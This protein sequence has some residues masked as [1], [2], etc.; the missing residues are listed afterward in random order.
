MSMRK[1]IGTWVGDRLRKAAGI[2]DERSQLYG[3]NYKFFG[4]VMI[5]LFPRGLTLKTP[6]DFARFA[7]Y[8]LA[9]VKDTRY[10]QQFHE[11]GHADSLD[12][13]VVYRT[14]LNELDHEIAA[15]LEEES[16]K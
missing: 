5:G 14:M 16:L 3:D 1:K 9:V 10:A 13:G 4:Q 6:D 12:D 8:T 7:L 11:G 15:K 2:F